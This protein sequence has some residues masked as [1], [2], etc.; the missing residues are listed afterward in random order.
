MN[1][2]DAVIMLTWSDWDTEP[3]SN[4]YHYASRFQKEVPV[5]FLQHK[6]QSVDEVDIQETQFENLKVINVSVGL[7]QS[8][9]EYIKV[10]L[11]K[12]GIKNPLFWI[13]DSMNYALL[14]DACPE[15]FRVYHATEDYLT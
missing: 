11:K 3:R 4:R 5:F 12:H 9:V 2:F 7:K 6:Y 10:L 8:E 14:L 13:Y 15:A 1:D